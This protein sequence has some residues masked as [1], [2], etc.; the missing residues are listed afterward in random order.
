M[1]FVEVKTTASSKPGHPADR[2]TAEKQLRIAKASL[3]YLKR[4]KML[5]VAARFDVV[6]V[7]WAEG[8]DRPERIEH[9]QAAFE[10]PLQYQMF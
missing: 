1:V 10:N 6:A 9:Y 3:R 7:W 2:V 5:G 4:Q 8:G